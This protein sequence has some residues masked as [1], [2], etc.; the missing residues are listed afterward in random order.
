MVQH[1][2]SPLALVVGVFRLSSWRIDNSSPFAANSTMDA[3]PLLIQIADA[4]LAVDLEAILIG[5]AGT[6]LHGAPVTTLDFEF[7]YRSSRVNE[8]KLRKVAELLGGH[9]SQP[10]PAL[11]TVFR[12]QRA[13][14]ELQVDLTSQIHG[15]KSFN[16]LRGNA[17]PVEIGGRTIIVAGLAD[18]IRSKRAANRPQDVACFMSSITPSKSSKKRK[19]SKRELA[20][21]IMRQG[22]EQELIG[23]I[24]RKLALPMNQRTHFLRVRLPNGGSCL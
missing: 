19:P 9:I 22:S 20:L 7:Y 16:R 6:A 1:Q 12:I 23:M 13:D 24:R 8:T 11:S 2:R 10:F 18:I 15:I 3:A 17:T 21:E 5:N 4:F 14:I